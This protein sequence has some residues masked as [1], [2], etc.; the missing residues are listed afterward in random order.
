[1][2]EAPFSFFQIKMECRV[3]GGG[4]GCYEFDEPYFNK[5]PQSSFHSNRD[6]SVTLWRSL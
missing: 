5:K 2:I 3:E 4:V 6:G 1:M